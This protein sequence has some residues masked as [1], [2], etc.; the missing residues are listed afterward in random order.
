M[1]VTLI[2]QGWGVGL[3]VTAST[4]QFPNVPAL[5]G[6]PQLAR[7]LLFPTGS[8]PSL[9]AAGQ[10]SVL[11][12]ATQT[13]IV[14]GV[15]DAYNNLAANADSVKDFGWRKEVRIDNFPIQ[16]GQF[17][18]YNRVGT[19]FECS[20]TLS[21]GGTLSE[22][23][24]FLMQIDVLIDQGNIG[25]YTIRTPEKSYVDVSCTRAELSRRGV[26]GFAYFDV[27]LYF[28]EIVPIDVQYGATSNN[29]P[30]LANSSVPSGVPTVNQALNNPQAVSSAVSTA[31]TQAITPPNPELSFLQML[32]Q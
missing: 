27:E 8:G 11:Y 4:P 10:Q 7:S 20:V 15:Y 18:T 22:R 25:L 29:T 9:G 32:A 1:S 14:W 24:A 12:Q 13:D 5:P 3:A 17:A 30:S 23:N 26:E 31:A 21:K 16:R 19:A 6:V 2:A 28:I